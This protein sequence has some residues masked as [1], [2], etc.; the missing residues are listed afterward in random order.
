MF[1]S[2]DSEEH[3]SKGTTPIN[4]LD[5]SREHGSLWFGIL[6]AFSRPLWSI[7]NKYLPGRAHTLHGED[8]KSI[9]LGL[10]LVPTGRNSTCLRIGYVCCQH[11]DNMLISSCDNECLIMAQDSLNKFG[12]QNLDT[13]PQMK[14][15]VETSYLRTATQLLTQGLYNVASKQKDLKLTKVHDWSPDAGIKYAHKWGCDEF[16]GSSE[17]LPCL[18]QIGTSTDVKF[19][20]HSHVQSHVQSEPGNQGSMGA[21]PKWMLVECAGPLWSDNESLHTTWLEHEHKAHKVQAGLRIAAPCS[22]VAVLKPDRHRRH[23]GLEDE[24][25]NIRQNNMNVCEPSL[26]SDRAASST[27]TRCPGNGSNRDKPDESSRPNMDKKVQDE[28]EQVGQNSATLST[29]NKPSLVQ[30]TSGCQNKMIAYILGGPCSDE[31]DLED[32]SDQDSDDDDDG[33]DSSDDSDDQDDDDVT[34]SDEGDSVHDEIDPES[35]RLWNSLCQTT[36]PYNPRNFTAAVRTTP[37]SKDAEPEA[38]TSGS[39]AKPLIEPDSFPSSSGMSCSCSSPLEAKGSDEF[40]EDACSSMDEAE[41]LKLWN[42]FSSSSDPYSPLN[43]Q[44]PIRTCKTARVNPKKTAPAGNLRYK[45]EEAEERMDSGFS[46]C[47]RVKKVSVTS[48][49]CW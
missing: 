34:D 33:F 24:L 27:E 17:H 6:S 13:K 12:L 48:T 20:H 42:S 32:S 41:S 5:A 16:R 18:Y 22:E 14:A 40:S 38:S 25:S 7:L 23:S 47:Y 15:Q 43:F 26:K 19:K 10:S 36:D 45:K 4:R 37:G 46:E 1:R 9:D 39:Q 44:A 2:V 11:K 30:S 3:F 49:F 35:E 28:P 8:G 31:S 29:E 21:V